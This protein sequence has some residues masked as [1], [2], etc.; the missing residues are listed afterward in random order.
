MQIFKMSRDI[1]VLLNTMW[2]RLL[3]CME[4]Y[5]DNN[6]VLIA[7]LHC[8][9]S[10]KGVYANNTTVHIAALHCVRITLYL[11]VNEQVHIA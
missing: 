2:H 1:Q 7:L 9:L 11:I 5:V 8:L 3:L 10:F 6:T 4:V